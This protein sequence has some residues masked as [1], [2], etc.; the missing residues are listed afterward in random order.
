MLISVVVKIVQVNKCPPLSD[1]AAIFL[2]LPVVSKLFVGLSIA[3]ESSGLV[4]VDDRSSVLLEPSLGEERLT[5]S[6]R[7]VLGVLSSSSI[8]ELVRLMVES[9]ASK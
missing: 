5:N 6:V 2:K 4:V 9:S 3:E 1:V 8:L 7:R